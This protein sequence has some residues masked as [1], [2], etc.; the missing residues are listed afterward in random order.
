MRIDLFVR[1]V[2][3][4]VLL[5]RFSSGIKKRLTV[6]KLLPMLCAIAATTTPLTL[7]NHLW[8]GE[9][10]QIFGWVERV[11]LDLGKQTI[12]LKA[13]LDTGA[14]SSS[15]HALDIR[16]FKRDG[17]SWVEFK[18]RQSPNGR[19]VLLQ[20]KVT[21]TVRIKNHD[22]SFESRPVVKLRVC[23]G[24]KSRRIQVNLVDRGSLIYPMLLGRT[25]LR[26]SVVV[27]PGRTF[28][29]NPQCESSSAR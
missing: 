5:P 3:D 10:R 29:F 7:T 4:L 6:L 26:G 22:G 8:A 18:V 27:D 21:R 19:P 12:D 17:K 9:N 1:D 23:L 11:R 28:L 20:R 15:L 2:Y 14:R 16:R 25:A 24:N 13:K